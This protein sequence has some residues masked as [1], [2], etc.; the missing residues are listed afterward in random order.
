MRNR[1][2][3]LLLLLFFIIIINIITILFDLV[4]LMCSVMAQV[5]IVYFSFPGAGE[6]LD[7]MFVQWERKNT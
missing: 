2:V 5:H 6:H 4:V 3:L 7:E 1:K